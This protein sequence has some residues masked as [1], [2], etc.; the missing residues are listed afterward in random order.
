MS[1]S[2]TTAGNF[3]IT[4]ILYADVPELQKDSSLI[5]IDAISGETK[6]IIGLRALKLHDKENHP[7]QRGSYVP[8]NV[9]F[10]K[11]AVKPGKA[12]YIVH[13]EGKHP[14]YGKEKIATYLKI[15]KEESEATA[16]LECLM[17]KIAKAMKV[18][19]FFVPTKIVQLE[20]E[21]E[22][23]P[24]YAI[25]Q[26]A[27]A[28]SIMTAVLK[29]GPRFIPGLEKEELAKAI[30][31]TILF[32]MFDAHDSN[33]MIGNNGKIRFF[34]NAQ[35]LPNSNRFISWNH[36]NFIRSSYRCSLLNLD[37]ARDLVTED[38]RAMLLEQVNLFIKDIDHL[39]EI[40]EKFFLKSQE[41]GLM[42][43]FP[44]GWLME[45]E[46]LAAMRQ[47][48]E[49]SQEVLSSDVPITLVDL[50]AKANPGYR[51]AFGFEILDQFD[52]QNYDPATMKHKAQYLHGHISEKLTSE[53]INRLIRDGYDLAKIIT[54]SEESPNFSIYTD[55]LIDYSIEA[56][57]LKHMP[58]P[59]HLQA[60]IEIR[61]GILPDMKEIQVKEGNYNRIEMIN[62]AI[63]AEMGIPTVFLPDNSLEIFDVP[64]P[65]FILAVNGDFKSYFAYWTKF[66]L[67][68]RLIK[69]SAGEEKIGYEFSGERYGTVISKEKMDGIK[70]I[71]PEVVTLFPCHVPVGHGFDLFREGNKVQITYHEEL[72]VVHKKQSNGTVKSTRLD[73]NEKEKKL[74]HHGGTG[75]SLES[76][77]KWLEKHYDEDR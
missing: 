18:R 35:S 57:Q 66:G 75:I 59:K 24:D 12:I 40:F 62:T 20:Y 28:G 72:L 8:L 47:R 61:R 38:L 64:Y 5:P 37:A 45:N 10:E 58:K 25:M 42:G 14:Q 43:S 68:L 46:V 27:V 30:L 41:N 54:L 4:A 34:D 31:V 55:R 7:G 71:P 65:Q 29:N 9:R 52:A 77:L 21:V 3:P 50:A 33:I 22:D 6:R 76:F 69:L 15:P 60:I 67:I 36:V 2:L 73:Y 63:L 19:G 11:G 48:L 16:M 17:W 1:N 56:R 44:D 74:S 51:L 23:P 26:P 32:G 53:K 49:L 39:P 13:A 70:Q